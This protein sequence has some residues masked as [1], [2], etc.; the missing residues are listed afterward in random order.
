[1]A[2][3]TLVEVDEKTRLATKFAAKMATHEDHYAEKNQ[4]KK[5]PLIRDR[6]DAEMV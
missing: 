2:A 6:G 5:G 4:L 1:M 3:G